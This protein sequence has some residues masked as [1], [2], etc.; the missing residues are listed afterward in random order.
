LTD[1]AKGEQRLFHASYLI[2]LAALRRKDTY[3][4]SI[5]DKICRV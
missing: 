4:F 1:I 5:N 3:F 2:A